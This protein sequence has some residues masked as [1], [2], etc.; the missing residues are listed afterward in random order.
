MLG[1]SGKLY[2]LFEHELAAQRVT[3]R[4]LLEKLLD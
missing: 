1:P 4:F 3:L 2:L